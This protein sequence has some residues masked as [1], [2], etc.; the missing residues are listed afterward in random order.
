MD[1]IKPS[2]NALNKIGE[3]SEELVMSHYLAKGY[4]VEKVDY[5]LFPFDFKVTTPN[6][7]FSVEVKTFGLKGSNTMFVETVTTPSMIVPEYLR[8]A[9]EVDVIVWV[10]KHSNMAFFFNNKQFSKYVQSNSKVEYS[11][12]QQTARGIFFESKNVEAGYRGSA[13][14]SSGVKK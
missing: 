3:H 4:Q 10:H 1:I 9:T 7:T 5:R 8:C 12:H 14:V 13:Y 11:N 6:G 2:F